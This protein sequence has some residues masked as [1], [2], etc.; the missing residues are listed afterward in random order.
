[1]SQILRRYGGALEN[2]KAPGPA[3]YSTEAD[4]F[5]TRLVTDPGSTQKNNYAALI[6]NL[7]TAGVWPLIDVLAI[8]AADSTGNALLN[9]KSSSFGGATYAGTPTFSAYTGYTFNTANAIDHSIIPASLTGNFAQDHASVGIWEVSAVLNN[10]SLEYN[11]GTGLNIYA[12]YSGTCYVRVND[13]GG[14]H[15][16]TIGSSI[17]FVLGVRTNSTTRKTY[18]KGSLLGTDTTASAAPPPSVNLMVGIQGTSQIAAFVLGGDIDA[19]QGALYTHLRTYMTA[20]GV[21]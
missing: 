16:I 9:L 10:P 21:P 8:Y 12:D 7:V 19:V 11:G 20:V 3:G 17:Q 1:M 14:G 18:H 4:Q 15:A 6:D 2:S 13:A 5:I